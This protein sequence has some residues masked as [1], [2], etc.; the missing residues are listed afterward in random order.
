MVHIDRISLLDYPSLLSPL[1]KYWG[2]GYALA[3]AEIGWHSEQGSC[4]R[5]MFNWRRRKSDCTSIE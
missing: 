1:G 5:C 2:C 3:Q 4:A